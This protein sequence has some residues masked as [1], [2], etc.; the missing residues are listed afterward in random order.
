M[1]FTNNLEEKCFNKAV[2]L[3]E[4]K[5][6]NLDIFQMADLLYKL[7]LEREEKNKK[8]DEFI[9]YN[10]EIVDI[11]D[12]GDK[13]CV[14]IS[15]SGDNL[16]YCNDILTKNSFG[17]PMSADI[18]F[19]LITSEELEELNQLLV[20]QLKNRYDDP[21]RYR[22]FIIGVDRSKM[23][24]YDVEDSAQKDIVDDKPI[25]DKTSFGGVD[26]NKF[27]DLLI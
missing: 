10:D 12:V 7:E 21:G 18:M 9:E 26:K 8:S 14:D 19:A 3:V 1:Q 20:K 5:L 17:V 23:K 22:R 16:F 24:L 27:N 25:F 11:I 2:F 6:T 4:N 13:E 15:V